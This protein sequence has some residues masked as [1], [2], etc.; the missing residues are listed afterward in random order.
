VVWNVATGTVIQTILMPSINDTYVPRPKD[1]N[2][3]PKI[4]AL[5]LHEGRLMVV[6]TSFAS[7]YRY[8][9]PNRTQ[10]KHTLVEYLAT[11]FV[12]T[13]PSY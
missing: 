3:E 11:T 1:R 2:V 10:P 9:D 13:I 4:Q 8:S 7:T 12:Y 5:L 6:V